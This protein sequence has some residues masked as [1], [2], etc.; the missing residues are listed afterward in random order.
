MGPHLLNGFGSL[1]LVLMEGGFGVQY[2]LSAMGIYGC[3]D[4]K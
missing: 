3:P 1:G 2:L 4:C